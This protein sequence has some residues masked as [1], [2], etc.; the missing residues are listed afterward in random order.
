MLSSDAKMQRFWLWVAVGGYLFA[1]IGLLP[2]ARLIPPHR[3][4]LGKEAIAAFW[5]DDVQLKLLGLVICFL[6]MGMALGFFV[7]LF[8]QM[9]RVE[10]RSAP[11]AYM[12]LAA[13]LLTV[14]Q[15]LVMYLLWLANAFRPDR[16]ASV[17]LA[18][19]D[20]AWFGFIVPYLFFVQV[21]PIALAAFKDTEGRVFPRWVGYLNLWVAVAGIPAIFM[22]FFKTGPI[23]WNGLITFWIFLV[24]YGSWVTIMFYVMFKATRGQEAEDQALD[25]QERAD[26]ETLD[27]MAAFLARA[28]RAEAR[29]VTTGRIDD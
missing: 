10:G 25:A 6:G 2:L 8:L 22:P 26:R 23:A 24:I 3:P 27:A 16:D 28:E 11:L 14:A 29:S 18:F 17:I 7:V 12:Q 21:I 1:C 15:G 13:G 20:I 5:A 19:N 4:S 9:Q